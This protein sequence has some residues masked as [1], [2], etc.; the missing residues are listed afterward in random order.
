MYKIPHTYITERYGHGKVQHLSKGQ[1]NTCGRMVTITALNQ[2]IGSSTGLL[3]GCC[4]HTHT[5]QTKRWRIHIHIRE[6]VKM[7]SREKYG[8]AGHYHLDWHP[9]D[10]I[11]IIVTSCQTK[12]KFLS[13]FLGWGA[14]IIYIWTDVFIFVVITVL[15]IV[16]PRLLHILLIELANHQTPEI[17][18]PKCCYNNKRWGH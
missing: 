1:S 15:A 13:K 10:P 12:M 4:V 14:I 8:I 9:T 7:N 11:P 16:S 18:W 2:V 6:G 3:V 17:Q 5:M